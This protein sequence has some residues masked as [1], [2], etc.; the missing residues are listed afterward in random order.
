MDKAWVIK[1]KESRERLIKLVKDISDTELK[2]VIYKE[3][4]TIAAALAHIAFWDYRRLVLMQKW[5]PKKDKVPLGAL[6]LDVYHTINDSILPFL[7]EIPPRKA[8]KL[9]V[10]AAETLDRKLEKAPPS[11]IAAIEATGYEL[12]L[13]R[14]AHRKIHMDEIDALLKSRRISK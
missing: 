8:A 9:A 6:E 3:G 11:L 4:W 1:N 7:L 2:L 10:L 12:G 14:S 5:K 13:N